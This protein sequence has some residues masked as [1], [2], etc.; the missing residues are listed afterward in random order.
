MN[1][2][3][4]EVPLGEWQV[5]RVP[6]KSWNS[7]AAPQTRGLKWLAAIVPGAVHYDLIRAGKLTNPFAS[8]QAAKQAEW[9]AENDWVYRTSFRLGQADL[10]NVDLVLDMDGVDTFSDV[11]VN[12]TLVG[13]TANNLRG[14]RFDLAKDH[15]IAGSNQLLVHVKA[16]RRLVSSQVPEASRRLALSRDRQSYAGKALIRRYPRSFSSGNASQ[17]NLGTEIL[18]I[19]INR[20]VRILNK[21][22][23]QIHDLHFH[24]GEVSTELADASVSFQ[25]VSGTAIRPGLH[26]QVSLLDPLGAQSVANATV[27]ATSDPTSVSLKVKNPKLWWPRGYGEPHLYRLRVEVK[28]GDLPVTFDARQ[29]G[30][31]RVELIKKL[32]S[33]RKTFKFV[34][35]G[36]EVYVRGFNH[37]PVDYIQVHGA[38]AEYE[39]LLELVCDAHANL[40]RIWGGGSVESERFYDACD[41][42]GLML[43]QDFFLHSTLYPDYDPT[44]VKEFAEESDELVRRLRNHACLSLLCG[45]NEQLQGWEEW[46]WQADVDSFY[47]KPLI[48]E[49]LPEIA[50]TLCPEVPYIVNSPHGG[51]VANSPTEG[52]VHFGNSFYQATKDPLFLT[53]TCWNFESYSRPRTLLTSMN[54][55][56]D[57]FTD[58][59]WPAR[60]TEITSRPLI[61]RQPFSG[62]YTQRTLREY[63]HGLEIEHLEADRQG[64]SLLRLRSGSCNGIVYWPLNKGTPLFEFGCVDY[65]GYPLM[66]FYLVKR[67]FADVALGL[68]RD[69]DDIRVVGSNLTSEAIPA[70]LRVIHLD[71]GGTVLKT[72]DTSV[73]LAPK[74]ISRLADLSGYYRAVTDRTRELVFA[75]LVVG[76]EV[77]CEDVLY[78]CP[79]AEFET[80]PSVISARADRRADGEWVVTV[81]APAVVKLLEIEGDERW[82]FGDNYFTLVPGHRRQITAR[83]LGVEPDKG[84]EITLSDSGQSKLVRC[85]MPARTQPTPPS[86]GESLV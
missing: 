59:G 6:R 21:P 56:V 31:K 42:L 77:L 78:F 4:R 37:V 32:E 82:L 83:L 1:S 80:E 69:I 85:E 51:R 54:L 11:W 49:L 23:V 27:P 74:G 86:A 8:S 2:D 65:A 68:Y 26:V 28:D 12:G 20:P 63:L 76:D 75:E 33:G 52:N 36:T 5:A 70:K 7:S 58:P 84:Y 46:G 13:Q 24:V 18:G 48:D 39:R 16:H 44:F 62:W 34:V 81:D 50:R 53:E 45:G 38:W 57:D 3:T 64:I 19:G 15:L 29:V 35:N 60:W 9:V 17:L 79:I 72:W 22:S 10:A 14:Y 43:W 73:S 41:E 40:V 55:D 71:N 61:T 47:G 66:N 30:I 25:L 67:L